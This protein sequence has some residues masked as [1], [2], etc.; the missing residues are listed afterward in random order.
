MTTG[1]PTLGQLPSGPRVVRF[2]QQFRLPEVDEHMISDNPAPIG[3]LRR[4]GRA[5]SPEQI[6]RIPLVG[7]WLFIGADFF[8][9]L[10]L[11]F[12]FF[13]LQETNNN[14]MWMPAGVHAPN[15][16]LG[17]TVAVLVVVGILV[18]RS[19]LKH[20]QSQQTLARFT[21]FG[22]SAAVLFVAAIAVDIWQLS[23]MGY[24]ISSGAY[25]S[26]FFAMWIFMAIQVA[27]LALWVISLAN[28]AGYESKHPIAMPGPDAVEEVPTPIS[29]LAHSYGMFAMFLGS[30]VLL[31]WVVTY[32]L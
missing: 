17:V 13:L 15:Q 7:T 3:G 9:L 28:R 16:A 11:F 22:R 21:S 6:A 10:P 31:A 30:A 24:G 18:A 20:L 4:G 8:F 26:V 23:H 12:A 1:M 27:A 5:H 32:F 29:A 25:A 19:G 14:H 2:R